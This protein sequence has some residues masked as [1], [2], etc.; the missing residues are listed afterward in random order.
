M[1][2]F[3]D[4]MAFIGAFFVGISDDFGDAKRVGVEGCL[5][6]ETVGGG[7]AEKTCYSCCEP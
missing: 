4:D 6:N 5:G 7:N 2:D 3:R 1:V